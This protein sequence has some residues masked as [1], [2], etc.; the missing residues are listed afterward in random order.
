L[1][2]RGGCFAE[3]LLSLSEYQRKRRFNKTGEPSPGKPQPQ[4]SA[5]CSWSSCTTRTLDDLADTAGMSRSAFA[6]MF[7]K[8][9]GMTPGQY[10]QGWRVGLAQRGIL[11]GRPLKVVAAEVG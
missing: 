9:L 10:L 2:Q 11:G 6:S 8:T 5:R 4:G 3:R 1:F 7:R